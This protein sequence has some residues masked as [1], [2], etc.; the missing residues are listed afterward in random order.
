[1]P[2]DGKLDEGGELL[3]LAEIGVGGFGQALAFERHHALI[4]LGVGAAVDGHGE[5]ALAEE[6]GHRA[7]E[8]RRRA[9]P[10]SGHSR[11]SSRHLIVGDQ[12]IDRPVGRSL[13][14]ELALE[15][16]RG[17][18]QR[19]ERHS[20]AEQLRHRL[21]IVMARQDGVDHGPELDQAADHVGLLR[22]ERQDQIVCGML[23]SMRLL[24]GHSRHRLAPRRLPAGSWRSRSPAPKA[25]G[26]RRGSPFAHAAGSRPRPTPPIAGR[27]SPP[28]SPRRRDGRGG[29]A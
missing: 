11:A 18:E 16:E 14:N 12:Q 25:R 5:M 4:A 23:S 10:R 7:A 1:M 15:F 24:R 3:G 22:L 26:T 9:R 29:N 20:L 19:G 2:R 21:G 13:E 27:R 28:P 17:A 8:A 6:G